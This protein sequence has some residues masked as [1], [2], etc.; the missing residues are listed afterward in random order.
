MAATKRLADFAERN[1]E[2]QARWANSL[3]V[4]LSAVGDWEGRWGRP[5]RRWA[6]TGPWP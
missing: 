2:Q 5:G 1:P 3:S 4:R 6:C